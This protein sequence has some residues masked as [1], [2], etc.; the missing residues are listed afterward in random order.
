MIRVTQKRGA[1]QS[2]IIERKKRTPNNI[3]SKEL[4]SKS[5]AHLIFKTGTL[6][7]SP[8]LIFVYFVYYFIFSI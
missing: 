6:M 5:W 1:A 8:S 4:K 2:I 3:G 7:M